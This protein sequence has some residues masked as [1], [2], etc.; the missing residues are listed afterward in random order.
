ML[1]KDFDPP[2]GVPST[3][4]ADSA[5]LV[6]DRFIAIDEALLAKVVVPLLPQARAAWKIAK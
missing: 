1:T 5:G 4:V 6:R 3:F 2:A